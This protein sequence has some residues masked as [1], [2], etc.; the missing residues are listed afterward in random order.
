[1]EASIPGGGKVAVPI[2]LGAVMYCAF[3]PCPPSSPVDLSPFL[4][5]TSPKHPTLSLS[6][7]DGFS[8]SG[9]G[10]QAHIEKLKCLAVKCLI[11]RCSP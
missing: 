2:L 5:P 1:M 8:M 3:P 4:S 9:A 10:E 7:A 11:V 6:S